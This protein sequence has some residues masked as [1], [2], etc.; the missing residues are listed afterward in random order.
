M[1]AQQSFYRR[2]L[3][4]SLV[5]LSSTEGRKRFTEALQGGTAEAFFAL[6]EQFQTQSEP[7]YCGLTTLS[8]VLNALSIDPQRVWKGPWRWFSEELLDCCRNLET[9]KK[10]GISVDEF[11][12]IAR[13]N[14]A[15]TSVV[16]NASLERWRDDI[17]KFSSQCNEFLVS[18]FDR[19]SIGQTGSGHFSPLAAY[20]KGTD[21]VLV[22]DVARF[23]YSP[24]WVSVPTL[25]K[26]MQPIDKV[27]GRS[28]GYVILKRSQISAMPLSC[29]LVTSY[30]NLGEDM[31]H[32]QEHIFPQLVAALKERTS[33][34]EEALE[35][36]ARAAG[37]IVH[38]LNENCTEL[39]EEVG[40]ETTTD[41]GSDDSTTK[42]K[43]SERCGKPVTE[44]NST[45]EARAVCC[46]P[47]CLCKPKPIP[48]VV[49]AIQDIGRAVRET[50]L[51][52]VLAS[53]RYS[54]GLS[55]TRII[56]ASC[57]PLESTVTFLIAVLALNRLEFERASPNVCANFFG[58][59]REPLKTE[60][61][62]LRQQL[63]NSI[64]SWQERDVNDETLRSA[65]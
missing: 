55:D 22:L 4:P 39:R 20:H 40:A 43:C 31:L 38:Y 36:F 46:R 11:S 51:Y 49:D 41:K 50:K 10:F 27:S 44:L 63:A 64:S 21:S 52:K 24:F 61:L 18:S 23:K 45:A 26:A 13:C 65:S 48:G 28:R 16:R 62:A 37:E 25:L 5:G 12:C 9:I 17:M 14:G 15:L 59:D 53:T 7:A 58:W 19:Q 32:I 47:I 60:I 42:N 56:T 2:P 3:P 1:S 29:R 8:V 33:S 54:S 57:A 34:E 30:Q 6:I 35:H